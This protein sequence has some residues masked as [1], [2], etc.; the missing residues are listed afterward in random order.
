[1]QHRGDDRL[2]A[3]HDFIKRIE[4]T[5]LRPPDEEE[6]IIRWRFGLVRGRHGRMGIEARK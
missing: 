4:I 1:M 3:E 2:M 6:V 5:G